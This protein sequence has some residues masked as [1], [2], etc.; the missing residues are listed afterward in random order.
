[1]EQSLPTGRE[2][3][4]LKV[5]WDLGSASVRRVRERMCPNEE[6]AFTTIQTF[7]RLMDDKGLVSH[8]RQGRQFVYTPLYSRERVTSRFVDQ[9][10]DGAM[11]QVIV[12]MLSTADASPEELKQLEKIIAQSRRRKERQNRQKKEP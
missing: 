4:I 5:L 12:S 9:I 8:K 6:L 1:M 10:F 7:L 3:E 11:D 2:L